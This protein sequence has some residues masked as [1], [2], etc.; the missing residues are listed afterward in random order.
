MIKG[1]R[2]LHR[3]PRKARRLRRS[4]AVERRTFDVATTRPES[5]ADHLMRISL[6]RNKIGARPLRSAPPRKPRHTQVEAPPEKMYRTV[7]ADEAGAEFLK[8]VLARNQYPK[9]AVRI[10]RIIRG[11]LRVG[12]EAHRVRHFDRHRPDF[13]RDS[14]RL[15]GRHE[16]RIKIGNRLRSQGQSLRRTPTRLDDQLVIDE[17]EL[18]LEDSVP[19]RDCRRSEPS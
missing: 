18:N 2:R 3:L 4:I 8:D 1:P 5:R 13:Y 10:L 15:Q 6:A 14:Q 17:V 12:R 11:M 16:F 19:V 9:E 7:F